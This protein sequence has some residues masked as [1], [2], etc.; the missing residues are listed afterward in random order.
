[1]KPSLITSQLE[2]RIRHYEKIVLNNGYNTI[3]NILIIKQTV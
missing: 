1:M 3:D 2:G